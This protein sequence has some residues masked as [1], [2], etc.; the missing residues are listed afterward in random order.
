MYTGT[1][2]HAK[3]VD[4]VDFATG[5]S[6]VAHA[7]G[8]SV[9]GTNDRLL[10][11]WNVKTGRE[12]S[13]RL[14]AA[15]RMSR[16]SFA[17]PSHLAWSIAKHPDLI[18]SAERRADGG[19]RVDLKDAGFQ[20]WRDPP[21]GPLRTEWDSAGRLLRWMGSGAIGWEFAEPTPLA[22]HGIQLDGTSGSAKY[23]MQIVQVLWEPEAPT[24]WF[25]PEH[26]ARLYEAFELE[27][28]SPMFWYDQPSGPAPAGHPGQPW[29][30]WASRIVIVLGGMLVLGGLATLIRRRT[31]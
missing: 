2:A 19:F 9:C 18:V 25:T 15:E 27:F 29:T 17:N 28:K 20:T 22:P 10:A 4:G 6:L 26:A 11:S 31:A 12:S 14:A 7:N 3:R 16:L 5:R 24:D 8:W 1:D 21:T 23:P 30:S 13:D